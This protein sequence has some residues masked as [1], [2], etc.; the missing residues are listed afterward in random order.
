[1]GK[2]F[3]STQGIVVSILLFKD[4]ARGEGGGSATLAGYPEFF[5]EIVANVRNGG[6]E[7]FFYALFHGYYY[8]S[9]VNFCQ[10][11]EKRKIN[12]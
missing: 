10:V 9:S 12:G 3:Y 7:L 8:N 2:A 11:G 6:D 5:F 1:M 4:D